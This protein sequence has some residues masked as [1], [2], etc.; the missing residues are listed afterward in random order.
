[1]MYLP[2]KAS[3]EAEYVSSWWTCL[4]WRLPVKVSQAM[5]DKYVKLTYD[6]LL[7][8]IVMPFDM[9]SEVTTLKVD[10]GLGDRRLR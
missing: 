7:V 10:K 6:P 3:Q 2:Y 1:M 9:A 8:Q 4:S 5:V